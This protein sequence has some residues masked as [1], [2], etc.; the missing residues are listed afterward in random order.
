MGLAATSSNAKVTFEAGLT[1][2][3]KDISG[4]AAP[5]RPTSS[6]LTSPEDAWEKLLIVTVTLLAVPATLATEIVDG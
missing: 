5:F 1:N 2:P 6:K 4:A 3:E